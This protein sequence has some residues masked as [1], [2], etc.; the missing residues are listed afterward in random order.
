MARPIDLKKLHQ[1]IQI[2]TDMVSDLDMEVWELRRELR[3]KNGPGGLTPHR[4]LIIEH[5]AN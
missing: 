5:V 3:K 2:L 4:G 1:A